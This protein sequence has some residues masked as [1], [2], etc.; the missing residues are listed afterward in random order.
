MTQKANLTDVLCGSHIPVL[1]KLIQKID[2]PVLELGIG[3]N[4]T[5][6]L[7]WMCKEKLLYLISFESDKK[8]L[9]KFKDFNDDSHLVGYHDFENNYLSNLPSLAEFDYYG[10][11]FVD[12]KPARKRRSSVRFFA[13][14]ADY[15]V[16]HDSELAD[17]PAYKYTPVFD[18]FK[19]KFEFKKVGKPYTM[20]L[21]NFKKELSWLNKL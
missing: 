8:W 7:H 3:Y 20:I 5:P 10:L 21:S 14:K 9:D 17:T 6:L 15:I 4:S 19:Y 2:K 12:H 13:N 16:V 11:V 1:I 18:E